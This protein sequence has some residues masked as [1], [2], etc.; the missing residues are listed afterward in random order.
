MNRFRD[1][2]FLKDWQPPAW[3]ARNLRV[4]VLAILLALAS[5]VV[6]VYAANPPDSRQILVHVQQD[7][8]Q[9]PGSFVLA[10]PIADIAVRITGTKEHVDN[11][12]NSSIRATPNFDAIKNVGVQQLPLTVVNTDPNVDLGDVPNTVTADVDKQASTSVPL[13]INPSKTQVGFEITRLTSVPDHVQLIGPSREIGIAV[14]VVDF[15]FGSRTNPLTQDGL[16][17]MVID[18]RSPGRPLTDVT[19]SPATVKV[20]IVIEP[21]AGTLVSTI[22]PQLIGSVAPNYRLTGV[23]ADPPTVTIKG[24]ENLLNG[25][26]QIPTTQINI[27]GLTGDHIFQI[28]LDAPSGLMFQLVTTQLVQQITVNV[29]V[30]VSA[31]PEAVVTPTPPTSAP[32]PASRSTSSSNSSSTCQRATLGTACPGPTP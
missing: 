8:Q 17:V 19:V 25:V 31:L 6:V 14:A 3:V 23:S 15:N 1:K 30:S 9:L 21:V 29:H 24:A 13:V 16:P 20:S 28:T 12:Q 7:S 5:W 27:S 10:H 11:F 18:R 22:L 26:Q 32:S 2:G 4:K